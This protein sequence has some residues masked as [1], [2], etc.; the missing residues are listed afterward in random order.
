MFLQPH[1]CILIASAWEKRKHE[2][3]REGG[4]KSIV[5]PGEPTPVIAFRSEGLHY[6]IKAFK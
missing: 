6:L 5:T 1:S 4:Q 3:Q 2:R